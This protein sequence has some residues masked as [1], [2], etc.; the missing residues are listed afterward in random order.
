MQFLKNTTSTPQGA[1][2]ARAWIPRPGR[3]NRRGGFGGYLYATA[4]DTEGVA[5]DAAV[6][7]LTEDHDRSRHRA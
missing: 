5:D 1:G 6:V 2:A 4:D 3:R 7:D